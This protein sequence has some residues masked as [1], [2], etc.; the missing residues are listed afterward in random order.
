MKRLVASSLIAT[1]GASNAATLLSNGPVVNGSGLS[2]MTAPAT[3]LG[4]GMQIT[5]G[6][7]VADDFVVPAGFT[8]DVSV[9][10]SLCRSP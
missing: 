2:V 10:V 8:W 1:S 4:Y 3:T 9:W 5:A 7:S 6:N